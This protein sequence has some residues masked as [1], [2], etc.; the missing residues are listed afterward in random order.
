[1]RNWLKYLF[2]FYILLC[3][4][5]FAMAQGPYEFTDSNT[6]QQTAS[7]NSGTI[8]YNTYLTVSL[9]QGTSL[10]HLDYD[11]SWH[12]QGYSSLCTYC[13]AQY[14]CVKI[15]LYDNT[16]NFV[17]TL[18]TIYEYDVTN[19]G[20]YYSYTGSL[21]FNEP[22]QS[23]YEIRVVLQAQYS[24]WTSYVNAATITAVTGSLCEALI[25]EDDFQTSPISPEWSTT[26]GVLPALFTYNS[27]QVFGPF[28][29]KTINLDLS[30]FNNNGR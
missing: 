7:A 20:S 27:T 23:G 13:P 18:E 25:F 2:V 21:D 8:V 17:Q 30:G 11:I 5:G 22:I 24:G 26:T 4:T 1:M 29:S 19:G 12:S 10:R 14:G 15:N 9:N 28:G 3:S 16:G 6:G